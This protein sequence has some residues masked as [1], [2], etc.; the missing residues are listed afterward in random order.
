[1]TKGLSNGHGALAGTLLWTVFGAVVISY[2]NE[3]A[4]IWERMIQQRDITDAVT[5]IPQTRFAVVGISALLLGLGAIVFADGEQDPD[6]A[7]LLRLIALAA[8]TAMELL[9]TLI[10]I[11]TPPS[12]PKDAGLLETIVRTSVL[13]G[14]GFVALI[15]LPIALSGVRRILGFGLAG[16]IVG[17]G[18][19][20]LLH[21]AFELL[22]VNGAGCG[23][24]GLQNCAD[25]LRPAI[26]VWGAFG[27]L[28]VA[29]Q[30]ATL[31]EGGKGKISDASH[32]GHGALV[33]AVLGL[34][35]AAAVGAFEPFS[36]GEWRTYS[37]KD[38]RIP[39]VYAGLAASLVVAN[40][41]VVQ[42]ASLLRRSQ[43]V[44]LCGVVS[45]VVAA[46]WLYP[47]LTISERPTDAKLQCG[48][49]YAIL[50]M[51]I[52]ASAPLMR[53][54]ASSLYELCKSLSER[55]AR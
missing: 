7:A 39:A 49:V 5:R 27:G 45:F 29:M 21:G 14:A 47:L 6:R 3:L 43:S 1:M 18:L 33:L 16:A 50:H 15:V 42:Q 23:A 9:K 26:F 53:W 34:G 13:T 40:L 20:M 44:V 36:G 38:G 12:D 48:A 55:K 25:P 46:Y 41:I 32:S 11:D 8:V 54:F 2:A 24:E 22:A 31:E 51:G 30:L 17:L 37:E 19:A 28:F 10:E 35:L 52:I 4:W